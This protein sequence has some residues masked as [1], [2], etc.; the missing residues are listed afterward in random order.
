MR[1]C[2]HH[3]TTQHMELVNVRPTRS[4]TC[5]PGLANAPRPDTWDQWIIS[6]Y[7]FAASEAHAPGTCP[8]PANVMG[9]QHL[10]LNIGL[11]GDWASSA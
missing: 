11:C 4:L 3:L 10:I 7:P 1:A 8:D 2:W 9:T 5:L 6:Y